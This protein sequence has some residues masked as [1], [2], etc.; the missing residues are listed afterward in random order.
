MNFKI[1]QVFFFTLFFLVPGCLEKSEPHQK[2]SNLEL[3]GEYPLQI[4]DP[5]GLTIDASGEFLWTVSDESGSSI[6]AISFTG[7]INKRITTYTADDLEG[8]TKNPNDG[9]LWIAEERMRQIV[10]LTVEG[11]VLQTVDIP[12]EVTDANN[13]LEGIAW[14]PLNDHIFILN[15]KRP[16]Q[17]IELDTDLNVVRSVF[18]NFKGLYHLADLSG[19]YFV[20]QT[21][22]LWFVSDESQK[23]VVTN[24]D[25]E[26][27]RHYDLPHD[28]F[29]GIAVDIENGIVYLVNDRRNSMFV[30]RLP[31]N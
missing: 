20:H 28:K 7:E 22:E 12:V 30:Y 13:G 6:Y 27:K 21:G 1:S 29:E 15:E 8:I 16:R 9:T 11:E 3:I 25:L 31:A 26:P 23:I 5:S 4:S 18:I 2:D 24:L 19:L 17:F 10:Q 14:N